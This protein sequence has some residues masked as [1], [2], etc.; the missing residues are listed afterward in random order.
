MKF[1]CFTITLRL[2]I[3]L[4]TLPIRLLKLSLDSLKF[5]RFLASCGCYLAQIFDLVKE[6]LEKV[7][8][9]YRKVLDKVCILEGDIITLV[10]SSC[11]T[12]IAFCVVVAVEDSFLQK[13]L[14]QH[15]VDF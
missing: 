10:E 5:S 8:V 13:A 3:G 7:S 4:D 6:L 2:A 15:T 14:S 12:P 9:L 1:C 11:M